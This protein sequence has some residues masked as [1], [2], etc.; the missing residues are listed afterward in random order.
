MVQNPDL[1]GQQDPTICQNSLQKQY[2]LSR[3]RASIRPSN[4]FICE[5]HTKPRGN[6]VAS[7]C[8]YLNDPATGHE[9]QAKK[10]VNFVML[11]RHRRIKPERGV[12]VHSGPCMRDVFAIDDNNISPRLILI[13]IKIIILHF[14]QIRHTDDFPSTSTRLVGIRL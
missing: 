10:G 3:V 8:V 5:K 7:T 2:I 12:C 9:C 11:G 1:A 4:F 6:W 13:I 14:I